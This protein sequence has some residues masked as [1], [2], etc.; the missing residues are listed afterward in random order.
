[1][2]CVTCRLYVVVAY[3]SADY[4]NLRLWHF[5]QVGVGERLRDVLSKRRQVLLRWHG[6]LSSLL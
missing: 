2:M 4:K 5:R 6:M 1:V 3:T